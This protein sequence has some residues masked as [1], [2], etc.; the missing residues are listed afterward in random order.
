MEDDLLRQYKKA[1]SMNEGTFRNEA[2]L[3]DI[4]VLETDRQDWQ[5]FF[6]F[7]RTSPYTV[8]FLIGGERRPLPERVEDLFALT[9]AHHLVI[10]IDKEHL[11]VNCY[12]FAEEGMEF[13]IAAKDFQDETT[14][15]E[16]IA[17]LLDFIRTIGHILNKVIILAP[18]VSPHFPLFRFDPSTKEEHWFLENI[19]AME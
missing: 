16:Q 3:R 11:A 10:R 14:I 8:E 17:R 13:D 2:A 15:R 12:C 1:F 9:Q 18:E 6:P 4:Y 19:D 7:L 5:T